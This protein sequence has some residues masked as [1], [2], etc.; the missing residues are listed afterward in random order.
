[1]TCRRGAPRFGPALKASAHRTAR[2][3]DAMVSDFDIQR[4][5]VS[6]IKEHGEEAWNEAAARYFD[7]KE[8]GDAAGMVVWPR[9]AHVICEMKIGEAHSVPTLQ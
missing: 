3:S 2:Y 7:M 1:M 4:S 5:A 8:K 9:V 6:L